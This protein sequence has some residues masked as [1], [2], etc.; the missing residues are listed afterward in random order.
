MSHSNA[1]V[2]GIT[3]SSGVAYALDFIDSLASSGGEP[4][5]VVTRWGM[6]LLER[7]ARINLDDLKKKTSSVYLEDELEAPISSGTVIT[8]ATVILPCSMTTLGKIAHGIADN[9]V[10]RSAHIALKEKRNLVL[11]IRETPLSTINLENCLKIAKAGGTIMPMTLSYYLSSDLKE[12]IHA[13]SLRLLQFL[14]FYTDPLWSP[15]EN[16]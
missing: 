5:V 11:C 9:L 2:V 12:L 15:E 3:G 4:I 14:G 8:R 7:E 1:V 16:D 6:K 13:F 10:T